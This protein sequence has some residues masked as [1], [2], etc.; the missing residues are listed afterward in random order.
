VITAAAAV[1]TATPEGNQMRVILSVVVIALIGALAV[2]A[3][4]ERLQIYSDAALTACTLSDTA[5]TTV[6]IYVA[7]YSW[8]GATGAR[9]RIAASNGFTGVWLGET[10][11][12]T[13][14]GTSPTDFSVGYGYC[15]TGAV[16]ILKMTYQLFGTSTC[17]TLS[18]APAAG[19]AQPLCAYCLFGEYPCDGFDDLHVNCGSNCDPVATEPATWGKIKALYRN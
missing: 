15:L 5:P 17:S 10:S 14:I 1:G 12:F 16:L 2:P 3:R 18:V 8:S 4:S 13:T 9:F 11:P 7:D 19:F 6:S